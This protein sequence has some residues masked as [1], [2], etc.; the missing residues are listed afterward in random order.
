MAKR[1]PAIVRVIR[2]YA[3]EVREDEQGYVCNCPFHQ[4]D[5]PLA[6]SMHVVKDEFGWFFRCFACGAAGRDDIDW[7]RLYV[8]AARKEAKDGNTPNG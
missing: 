1:E 8:A 3:L 5:K 7:K 2:S 6:D 4:S